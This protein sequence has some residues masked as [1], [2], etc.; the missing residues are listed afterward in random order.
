M[1]STGKA[2]KDKTI[3]LQNDRS[4]VAGVSQKLFVQARDSFG[5]DC[6]QGNDN[7]SFSLVHQSGGGYV[8]EQFPAY[9]LPNGLYSTNIT[10]YTAGRYVFQAYLSGIPISG[11][12]GG[13]VLFGT[14]SSITLDVSASSSD[15]YYTGYWILIGYNGLGQLTTVTDY[16]GLSKRCQL[17]DKM[18][19]TLNSS[20]LYEL[21][22]PSHVISV[23]PNV[24]SPQKTTVDCYSGSPEIMFLDGSTCGISQDGP[25]VAS[26]SFIFLIILRDAYSNPLSSGIRSDRLSVRLRN[27]IPGVGVSAVPITASDKWCSQQELLSVEQC[28]QQTSIF[29]CSGHQELYSSAYCGGQCG[30]EN[31]TFL[32]FIDRTWHENDGS[33][34]VKYSGT[35]SVL[36]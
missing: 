22:P 23:V 32:N 12:E 13:R 20:F 30:S 18:K 31:C 24:V 34:L 9:S 27:E 26:E 21:F 7:I 11:G 33:L 36:F 5:M 2:D 14:D 1:S 16:S 8:L 4:M 28:I 10:G 3:L 35:W 15:A 6:A 17:G 19:I 29:Q 25:G